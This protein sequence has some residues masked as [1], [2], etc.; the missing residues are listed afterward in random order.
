MDIKRLG[1]ILG[2]WCG[3]APFGKFVDRPSTV[4]LDRDVVCFD[5]KG[6]HSHPDLQSVCLFIIT[7]LIWRE[8]QRDRTRIKFTIFDEC[9]K[10]LQD[11][12]AAQFVGEVYRTYRKYRASA[13]A[14]SQAMDD[15]AKSKV[16]AAI[17]PNSSVK[18]LLKQKITDHESFKT[19][20]QLNPREMEL[21]SKLESQKGQFS[22]AF[23]MAEDN[24][25][26]VRIG[27]TPLEYW[28]F[29]SDPPDLELMNTVKAAD[30]SLSDLEVLR[31][32]AATHPQGA[33]ITKGVR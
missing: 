25:Q 6:L 27:S 11:E 14:I 24:R 21:I 7:D 31:A 16:A 12:S 2:L 18:W 29:T 5:L 9:W 33:A 10:I 13:I 1:R 32:C 4:K 15:F 8:V 22:E 23:L 17:L 26:V 20:L 28:L 3:D 19:A 30:P